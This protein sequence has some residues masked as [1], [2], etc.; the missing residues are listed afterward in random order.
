LDAW[1]VP[2]HCQLRRIE[3]EKLCDREAGVNFAG[4]VGIIQRALPRYRAP[5]FDL[6][7]SQTKELSIFA[8]QPRPEE[9]IPSAEKLEIAKWQRAQNVHLLSGWLYLCYQRGVVDWLGEW[10]PDALIVEANPR[11]LS[12]PA[13]VRWMHA[14]GR[15][16]L[17]WGLGAP[18]AQGP[19]AAWRTARRKRFLA[20]FD[21]L[22]AYSERGAAEYRSAGYLA[23]RIFVAPNAVALR[24]SK[25]PSRKP[26]SGQVRLLYVGR[27]QAR[28][29][30]PALIRACAALPAQ[31]QPKLVLVGDGPERGELEKLSRKIYP[32]TEFTGALFGAELDAQ[33]DAADLFVLP[34]TGGLA[35]QQAMAHGLPV[36]VAKG[37]G[38]QADL[39]QPENGWLLPPSNEAALQAAFEAALSDPAILR[40]KGENSFKRVQQSYNLENMVSAFM[41]ALNAVR[42]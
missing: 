3:K 20:Q 21:G 41:N 11:Y 13:A 36:I 10:N 27:L 39:V 17:G 22:I 23:E 40:K 32:A 15:P 35:V 37:D 1:R 42:R 7:A 16:V 31:L 4:R 18:A 2:K 34:G 8:G 12:T 30:L 38:S 29:Q 33:F 9:A 19:L 5:F 28:K 26:L 24:P 6:L 25:L 14:H